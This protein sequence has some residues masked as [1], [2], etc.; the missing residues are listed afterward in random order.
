V[1]PG[2]AGRPITPVA[3]T[4][5]NGLERA[6]QGIDRP[7]ESVQDSAVLSGILER[8]SEVLDRVA[9]RRALLEALSNPSPDPRTL[10]DLV[11]S[12]PA[13]SARVLRSVNSPVYALR[14]PMASVFRAVLY[15]GYLEVRNIVWKACVAEATGD[16]PASAAEML[17]AAWRH[18]F[19]VSRVAYALARARGIE[20]PDT[21]AT[22]ALL[23]DA[24][25]LVILAVEPE[26]AAG[27]YQP[28]CFGSADQLRR[29][30]E[31]VGLGHG[32]LGGAV[33]R[34]WGLPPEVANAVEFHHLPTFVSPDHVRGDARVVGL[35]HLADLLCHAFSR[36]GAEETLHLPAE[37]WLEEIGGSGDLASLCDQTVLRALRSRGG[38][39][40]EAEA[41]AA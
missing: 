11:V 2:P 14:V 20:Q 6:P 36:Q 7:W 16:L 1:V 22:A 39:A 5:L 18:S 40:A 13:L 24:G 38:D 15:L 35:V 41:K 33:V 28:L 8:A 10:T 4:E 26:T 31:A 37:G 30:W 19:A 27:I 3:I 9:A 32:L 23:H 29:E 21:I 34:A 12:D 17:D 25:K